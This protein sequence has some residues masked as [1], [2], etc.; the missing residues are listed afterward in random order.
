MDER[1]NV[2][3]NIVM[4]SNYMNHHQIPFCDELFVLTNGEFKFI[5][6]N[7]V[8]EFRI[9]L[10]YHNMD[11]ERDYII[12]SYENEGSYNCAKKICEKADVLIIG[13]VSKAFKVP[14]TK[15]KMVFYYSERLFKD[16]KAVCSNAGRFAKYFMKRL[17]YKNT[18]LL[19]ASAYAAHDY[20]ITG[21]FKKN[22]LKWGYFPEAFDYSMT[23]LIEKKR[24]ETVKILWVGRL[25]EWKHPELAVKTAK[26]LDEKKIDFEME[27]IGEGEMEGLLKNQIIEDKLSEKVK[28]LGSIPQE[29]VRLHMEKANIY[30]FTSDQNEGWGA[31]LN[32]AMNAACAV[33]GC[34]EAGSV[35]YLINNQTGVVFHKNDMKTLFHCCEKLALNPDLVL[36]IGLLA[37][38]RIQNVWNGK[39]AARRILQVIESRQSGERIDFDDGPCSPA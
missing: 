12:A 4:V 6:T 13:N 30:L 31:V 7:P 15:H 39:V 29:E 3:M 16:I 36:Q 11:K 27:I 8:A 34:L 35:P 5:A 32:E 28:I 38:E 24:N 9:N 19:C 10:G 1:E 26:Y 25:I 37:H 23:D 21:N 22:A 2:V 14:L 20:R 18:Y 33:I 17:K